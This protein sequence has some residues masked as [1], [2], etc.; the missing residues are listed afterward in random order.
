MHEQ[1]YWVLT[2]TVKPGRFTEFKQVVASLVT[3]AKKEPGT[4]V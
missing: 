4:C 1:I 2:V 3:A